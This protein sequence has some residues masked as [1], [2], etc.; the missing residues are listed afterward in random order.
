MALDMLAVVDALAASYLAMTPPTGERPVASSTGRL[1]NYPP[2]LPAVRIF[3]PSGATPLYEQSRR[4]VQWP[5]TVRFYITEHVDD[6]PNNIV[7]LYKWLNVF[8]DATHVALKLGLAPVVDKAL[9]TGSLTIG[10]MEY[11]GSVFDGI[12]MEVTV[13]TTDTVTLTP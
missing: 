9:P 7:L 3:P 5:F 10:S 11:G 6:L 1:D 13:W 12:E 4:K 2:K 8:V